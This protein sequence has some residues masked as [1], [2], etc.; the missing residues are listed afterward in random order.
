[1]GA[2]GALLLVTTG[3]LALM[4]GSG[5]AGTVVVLLILG[6]GW[7]AGLIG[8]SALLREARVEPSQQTWAEGLGELGMGAAAAAGGGTAGL[9]LGSGG[10]ATLCLVAAV[11]CLL[12]LAAIAADVA[13]RPP[14]AA[15]TVPAGEGEGPR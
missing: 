3:V 1:V 11:P 2:G 10:F 4:A 13:T 6:A 12:L 15:G 9:V 5:V 7:N 14:T 8:G